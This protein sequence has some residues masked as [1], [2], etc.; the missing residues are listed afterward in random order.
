MKKNLIVVGIIIVIIVVFLYYQSR[1]AIVN[2]SYSKEV[3]EI[4]RPLYSDYDMEEIGVDSRGIL[5]KDSKGNQIAY[6]FYEGKIDFVDIRFE[7]KNNELD[8]EETIQNIEDLYMVVTDNFKIIKDY[9][10]DDF[11]IKEEYFISERD[12]QHLKDSLDFKEECIDWEARY[13]YSEGNK[14][15]FIN[16]SMDALYNQEGY[17]HFS[18]FIS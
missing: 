15:T 1:P 8:S 6:N 5:F 12:R 4:L 2:Y 17:D 3:A 18:I 10:V 16:Y 9:F 11:L 13:E 7:L 14:Y